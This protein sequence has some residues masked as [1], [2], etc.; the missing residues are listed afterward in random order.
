MYC[1]K[2]VV[3]YSLHGALALFRIAMYYFLI[4]LCWNSLVVVN[5]AFAPSQYHTW[6]VLFHD[7][8]MVRHA[9]S[10]T[11]QRKRE[12]SVPIVNGFFDEKSRE[13]PV[14]AKMNKPGA[15]ER[16]VHVTRILNE[17]PTSIENG[18]EYRLE[19]K[20][21]VES[22]SHGEQKFNRRT[23]VA[24]NLS[25]HRLLS[26]EEEAAAG[27]II[28]LVRRVESVH[29]QLVK[30]N[31]R[32]V[33]V[34]TW[35][36]A[37]NMTVAHLERVT[38]LGVRART[39][40]VRHNI[41]YVESLAQK[42]R[43]DSTK[44]RTVPILD[45]ISAGINGLRKASMRYDGRDRFLKFAHIFVRREMYEAISA[46]RPGSVLSHK[47]QMLASRATLARRRLSMELQRPVTNK[48]VA[49]VLAVSEERLSSVVRDAQQK[50]T[51]VSIY[52]AASGGNS[53]QAGHGSE[54]QAS[55]VTYLDL[56]LSRDKFNPFASD[57]MQWQI[58]FL[59]ALDILQ[60]DEKRTL[61]LRY[62]LLDNNPRSLALTA[63][64]MC[65]SE[66]MIRKMINRAFEKIRESPF[67]SKV[68]Q[69]GPNKDKDEI[70]EVENVYPETRMIS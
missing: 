24:R 30:K 64:L 45:L 58:D 3:R 56:A 37:C 57:T 60:S 70:M 1:K 12:N 61:C 19:L 18:E 26:G 47:D 2:S 49:K 11:A 44:A 4:F 28:A 15:E 32:D 54:G 50:S 63:E 35:A 69:A 21:I 68:L 67:A 6:L 42:L 34:A 13:R 52:S 55:T 23:G 62:G 20:E 27:K 31:N 38:L 8:S 41:R 51:V 36:A 65:V 46:L 33:S 39:K 16:Q 14:T 7:R 25:N 59:S 43:T 40:L 17:D 9:T 10:M 66:E 53:G 5:D 22:G 29:T 48:E